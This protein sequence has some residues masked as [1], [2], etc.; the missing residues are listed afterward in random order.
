MAV[1]GVGGGKELGLGLGL[2]QFCFVDYSYNEVM[3]NNYFVESVKDRFPEAHAFC[4]K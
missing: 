1:Y 4:E 3:F 2:L